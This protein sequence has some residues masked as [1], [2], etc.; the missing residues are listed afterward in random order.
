MSYPLRIFLKGYWYH[1]Y[2]RGQRSQPLFFSQSDK[3]KYMKLLDTELTRRVGWIG[4]ICLMTN[5]IH[6]LIRMGEVEISKVF[7]SVHTRYAMYFNKKR[8]TKGHV[9][10]GRPGMKIIL[11]ENYIVRLVIYMHKNPV[12]AGIVKKTEEYKW[13]SDSLF[14]GKKLSWIELKSWQFPPGLDENNSV[15]RYRELMDGVNKTLPEDVAYIGTRKD[16][17]KIKK[18]KAGREGRKFKERR[19]KR[20]FDTIVKEICC[21]KKYTLEDLKSRSRARGISQL[22]HQAMVVMY[23][24]GYGVTEIGKYFNRVPKNVGKAYRDYILNK[25]H[26]SGSEVN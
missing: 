8:N 14:R 12:R 26:K 22:R 5:H 7:Q 15:D 10:Q 16:Y 3:I 9:F 18:R 20:D 17:D 19:E 21:G 4:G 6:L 1:V 11:N 24:E 2:A 25:G 23:E 13:S